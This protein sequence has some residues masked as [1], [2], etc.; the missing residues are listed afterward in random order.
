MSVILTF[1]LIYNGFTKISTP[2]IAS[3]TVPDEI[4]FAPRLLESE[5]RWRYMK[6]DA[7]ETRAFQNFGTIGNWIFHR[8]LR[9]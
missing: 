4:A 9:Y 3:L 6:T 5:I 7:P 1:V 8:L 2:I